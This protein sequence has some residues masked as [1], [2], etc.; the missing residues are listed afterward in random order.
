[1]IPRKILFYIGLILF[2]YTC[3]K[4]ESLNGSFQLSVSTDTSF[5]AIG[6]LIRLRIQ[7]KFLKDNYLVIPQTQFSEPLELRQLEPLY[8]ENGKITGI[9]YILSLIHI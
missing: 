3:E 8:N 9:D 2:F 7:T 6:D 1:M 4:N 5:A